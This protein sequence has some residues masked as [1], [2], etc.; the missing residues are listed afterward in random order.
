MKKEK[1]SNHQT[2]SSTQQYITFIFLE[3]VFVL[4]LLLLLHYSIIDPFHVYNVGENTINRL[5]R[6]VEKGWI[7][8]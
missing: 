7:H 2:H 1:T 8:V 4:L 5:I 6:A 3:G